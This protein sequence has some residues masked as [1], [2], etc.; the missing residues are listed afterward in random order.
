M[1]IQHS[2]EWGAGGT[3]VEEDLNELGMSVIVAGDEKDD[4]E[5]VEEEA[6]EAGVEKPVEEVDE[7]IDGLARLDMLEKSLEIEPIDIGDEE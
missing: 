3:Q 7:P 4:L 2:D 1:P 6:G 5:E